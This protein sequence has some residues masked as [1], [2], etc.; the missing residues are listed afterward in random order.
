MAWRM[1]STEMRISTKAGKG[2]LRPEYIA[3]RQLNERDHATARF[4]EGTYRRRSAVCSIY[5]AALQLGLL[6]SWH[7]LLV[8][9]NLFALKRNE[10][11]HTVKEGE[12]Y[13]FPLTTAVCSFSRVPLNRTSNNLLSNRSFLRRDDAC[14]GVPLRCCL[15]HR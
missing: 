13:L 2:S 3:T 8:L 11:K 12:R 6:Q 15:S 7:Y 5:R 14:A 10:K 4:H 9:V 1:R